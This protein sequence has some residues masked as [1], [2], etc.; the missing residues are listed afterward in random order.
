MPVALAA[1]LFVAGAAVSLS[2][3]YVLVTRLERIGARLRRPSTVV[4][5]V[6]DGSPAA[7]AGLR[8]GDRIIAVD[9]E[10]VADETSE[11]AIGKIRGPLGST[12]QVTVER[13]GSPAPLT[14]S[15]QR[16]E[17]KLPFVRWDVLQRADG[18]KIGYLQIRGFPEPSVDDRVGHSPVTG[19]RVLGPRERGSFP[20]PSEGY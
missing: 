9:G 6:F 18:S 14:F 20:R 1:A 8:T 13:R 16:A 11:G 4:L 15:L 5:E 17:I 19:C 2:T 3:S 10:S 7:R 12:V